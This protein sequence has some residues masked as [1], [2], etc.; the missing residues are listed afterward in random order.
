[1]RV[2][3]VVGD[4]LAVVTVESIERV[5][6]EINVYHVISSQYYNIISNNILTTNGY[7]LT[8]NFYGFEDQNIKWPQARADFISNPNNLYTYN[9]F[10]DILPLR[11]FNDLRLGEASYLQRYG[12]TLQDFR[13]YLISNKVVEGMVPYDDE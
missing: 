7:V 12:I 2:Y 4:Q 13:Q 5:Q 11:M 10:A 6:E 1:V 8:S 3:K 9:D